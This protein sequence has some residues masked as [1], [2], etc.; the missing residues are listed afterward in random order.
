M[1][2]ET[3]LIC[4]AF[5]VRRRLDG[6][7]KHQGRGGMWLAAHEE[8]RDE[9]PSLWVTLAVCRVFKRLYA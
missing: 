4:V 8:T 5:V 7:V 1:K 3:A 2:I 6:L 9:A